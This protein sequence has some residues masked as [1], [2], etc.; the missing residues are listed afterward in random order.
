MTLI[1]QSDAIYPINCEVSHTGVEIAVVVTSMR[2][3]LQI[4]IL[5]VGGENAHLDNEP[6]SFFF[7]QQLISHFP[8]VVLLPRQLPQAKQMRQHSSTTYAEYSPER[9]QLF[10][11]SIPFWTSL[12][13]SPYS[14]F[15]FIFIRLHITGQ[16][17]DTHATLGSLVP[18][19]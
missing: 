7:D 10:I 9:P 19:H 11:T 18:Q 3:S 1:S 5:L 16:S 8:R 13:V 14:K 2:K 6:L 17:R 4:R 12:S 15:L